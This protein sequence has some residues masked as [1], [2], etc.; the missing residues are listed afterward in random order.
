MVLLASALH[1]LKRLG[2]SEP[3]RQGSGGGRKERQYGK[4]R[5]TN[6][7][8][9]KVPKQKLVKTFA[10]QIR[11]MQNFFYRYCIFTPKL[12]SHSTAIIKKIFSSHF[13]FPLFLLM[14]LC[15]FT[16]IFPS[17]FSLC[18]SLCLCL[19]VSL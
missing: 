10:S 17:S 13:L 11:R 1:K 19:S 7:E 15:N 4:I 9:L 8:F 14:S 18:L 16:Y 12:L 2:N 5:Q 3:D 6:S